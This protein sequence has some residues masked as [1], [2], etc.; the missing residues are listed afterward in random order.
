MFKIETW[1]N[2][3]I[4]RKVADKV[5]D[6][7][8]KE[9][10]KLWKKMIKYIKDPKNLWVWLAAPQVW[11]SLRLI[12]VSMLKDRDDENFKTIM[13]INPEILEH[14]DDSKLE[15]E[16]CLSV[17]WT[18]WNVKRFNKIKLTYQDEKN[19]QITL[20]LEWL[21][22]RIIQHEIDHINWVLFVDLLKIKEPFI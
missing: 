4:L 22:A 10:V 9:V 17:P 14:W 21:Q 13:L 12:V 18:K 15:V 6:K 2:N 19:S 1:T 11:A 20:Y 5:T 3:P 8:F 7:N 16:W